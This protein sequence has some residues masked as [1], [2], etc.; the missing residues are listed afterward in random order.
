MRKWQKI[1]IGIVIVVLLALH[2]IIQYAPDIDNDGAVMFITYIL[3]A[4][5]F[6][7]ALIH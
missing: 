4:V 7:T 3:T 1:T 2:L 6:V 5:T